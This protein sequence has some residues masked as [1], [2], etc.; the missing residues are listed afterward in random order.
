[1]ELLLFERPDSPEPFQVIQLDPEVNRTFYAW[2]VYVEALP[3]G[4]A[5][6]WRVDGPN[7]VRKTGRRFDREKALLDP[8]ARAVTR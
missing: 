1:M 5:Y 3:Q 4:T 2:H 8:W 6:V 7:D